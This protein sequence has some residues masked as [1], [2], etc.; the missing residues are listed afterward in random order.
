MSKGLTEHMEPL[1]EFTHGWALERQH[2]W[3]PKVSTLGSAQGRG[4][5]QLSRK[6]NVRET[7]CPGSA[8]RLRS[9]AGQV[10]MSALQP[11]D[12]VTLAH[13]LSAPTPTS[14][15]SFENDS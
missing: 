10:P 1:M 8:P 9:Q 2:K 3:L 5:R 15:T 6:F 12:C 13:L 4:G 14:F 7:Q 11:A